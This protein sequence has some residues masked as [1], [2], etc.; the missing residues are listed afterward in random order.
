M[1]S[2]QGLEDLTLTTRVLD[3]IFTGVLM[4]I[5]VEIEEEMIIMIGRDMR[6]D[7]GKGLKIMA[8]TGREAMVVYVVMI[9]QWIGM[10][11][12]RGIGIIIG[13]WMMLSR[14]M[15]EIVSVT[16]KE[17]VIKI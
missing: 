17:K 3:M 11:T 8:R 10:W 15:G 12:K 7:I 4:V 14:N 6:R 9:I 2:G 1:K 13:I 5:E 16:G